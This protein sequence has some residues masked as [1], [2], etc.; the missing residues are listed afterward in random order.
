MRHVECPA[1]CG[2]GELAPSGES[3]LEWRVVRAAVIRG[4]YDA[5]KTALR[6]R[7]R[8]RAEAVRA[9]R[10]W[11]TDERVLACL[12]RV[13]VIRAEIRKVR[14]EKNRAM[15]YAWCCECRGTGRLD[16]ICEGCGEPTD[17]DTLD[18]DAFDDIGVVVHKGHDT[19]HRYFHDS[20]WAARGESRKAAAA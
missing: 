12:T 19:E 3:I 18:T 11:R 8:Y 10:D 13:A 15:T 17:L 6:L 9:R 16:M 20:S 2:D 7:R 4:L 1:C 14:A 5:A